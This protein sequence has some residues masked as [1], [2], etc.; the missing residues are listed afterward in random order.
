MQ[1]TALVVVLVLG[2]IFLFPVVIGTA[3]NRLGQRTP[4][5]LVLIVDGWHTCVA[6][7]EDFC[8]SLWEYPMFVP[9][10]YGRALGF[11]R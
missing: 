1:L 8:V 4:G 2:G 9:D 5:S 6:P 3:R 11:S 7:N 10:W